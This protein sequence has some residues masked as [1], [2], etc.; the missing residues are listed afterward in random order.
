MNL[1]PFYPFSSSFPPLGKS[2]TQPITPTF[3]STTTQRPASH[4]KLLHYTPSPNLATWPH[5]DIHPG[6]IGENEE[7]RKPAHYSQVGSM[8]SQVWPASVGSRNT[9]IVHSSAAPGM[10][11]AIGVDGLGMLWAQGVMS[12]LLRGPANDSPKIVAFPCTFSS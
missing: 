9:S 12:A 1:N 11:L 8:G 10:G 5:R 4:R 7:T 2:M 6:K 3:H